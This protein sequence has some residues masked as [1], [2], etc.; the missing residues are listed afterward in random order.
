MWEVDARMKRCGHICYSWSE[1]ADKRFLG[2]DTIRDGSE[3]SR[4]RVRLFA[5]ESQS[6]SAG[7]TNIDGAGDVCDRERSREAAGVLPATHS[8]V[9]EPMIRWVYIM[10]V[11]IFPMGLPSIPSSIVPIK[12]GQ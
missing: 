12:K 6:W 3:Q 8:E 4:R 10:L 5:N 1:L 7:C 11:V 9:I 2:L